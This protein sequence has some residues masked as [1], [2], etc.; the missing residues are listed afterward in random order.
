[1][2]NIFTMKFLRIF[3]LILIIIGLGLLAT[4]K[5]WVPKL[6]DRIL[7]SESSRTLSSPKDTSYIV[8]IPI[9][10]SNGVSEISLG[11]DSATKITTR[12]FGEPVYGDINDDG[13]NDAVM[14]M[15]QEGGGS[16]TFFYVAV[17]IN[18]NG[19]FRGTKAYFL[20]D[21]IAPQ[22]IQVK[23]GIIMANYADR[24]SGESFDIK[25]SLG[26]TKYIIFKDGQLKV[27]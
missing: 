9:S 1:M 24:N 16:G 7:S 25:P 3:L 20:G 18:N 14:F 8:E 19:R 10:L 26:V 11:P 4:Q 27:K 6:V 12:I 15:T 23:N 5:I 2:Q 13:I 21:R 17:A 22:T